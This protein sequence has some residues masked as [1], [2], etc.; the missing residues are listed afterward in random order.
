MNKKVHH[1]RIPNGLKNDPIK[2]KKIKQPHTPDE[3]FKIH[4]LIAFIGHRGSGKTHALVN[5]AKRYLDEGSFT[6]VFCISPTFESNP[7]FHILGIKKEDVYSNLH[8]SIAAIEDILAKCK[9]DSDDFDDYE[10]YMNAYRKWKRGKNLKLDEHTMLENNDFQKPPEIPRPS[11]LIVIDDMSHSDIYSTSRQNPFINLCLRHRHINHGKGCSIFMCV[12][13]FRSGIPLALRQNLQVMCIWPTHDSGQLEAIF[14]ES[15]KIIQNLK[16]IYKHNKNFNMPS[17]KDDESI[18]ALVWRRNLNSGNI[19]LQPM[20]QTSF[21]LGSVRGLNKYNFMDSTILGLRNGIPDNAEQN[22]KYRQKI[23]LNPYTTAMNPY[24]AK[25]IENILP[26]H[27]EVNP[28]GGTAGELN[29]L[30]SIGGS[31]LAFALDDVTELQ[32]RVYVESLRMDPRNPLSAAFAYK[33][34]LEQGAGDVQKGALLDSMRKGLLADT[35]NMATLDSK[36]KAGYLAK[37][38]LDNTEKKN[39]DQY[40]NDTSHATSQDIQNYKDLFHPNLLPS[41][42]LPGEIGT[43]I[44]AINKS[45]K[46]MAPPKSQTVDRSAK[47]DQD[48]LDKASKAAADEAAA[49]IAAAAAAEAVEEAASNQDTPVNVNGDPIGSSTDVLAYDNNHKYDFYNSTDVGKNAKSYEDLKQQVDVYIE[50]FRKQVDRG[51]FD[52]ENLL[53][54]SEYDEKNKEFS[55]LIR[56]LPHTQKTQELRWLLRRSVASILLNR[57]KTRVARLFW[58]LMYAH[59]PKMQEHGNRNSKATTLKPVTKPSQVPTTGATVPPTSSYSSK[60]GPPGPPGIAGPVVKSSKPPKT[61]KA[62]SKKY[63]VGGSGEE[64]IGYLDSTPSDPNYDPNNLKKVSKSSSQF[65][66]KAEK[67]V[68]DALHTGGELLKNFYGNKRNGTFDNTHDEGRKRF[69]R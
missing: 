47:E 15:L 61:I 29:N 9:T 27:H 34:F 4:S 18:Q 53:L 20:Q 40:V 65:L 46:S 26:R 11:P 13:N 62:P 35:E 10:A 56:E 55:R 52:V 44:D 6:R 67:V 64:D 23:Q 3:L 17:L 32:Q 36:F 42:G 21:A 25:D 51:D 68:S 12:Q 8:N 49:E 24:L 50:A 33:A 7:V 19:D 66:G 69:R 58:N 63:Y 48:A 2:Y 45:Y 54:K 38:Q 30:A 43:S 39:L 60:G 41:K 22:I 59:A 5:L 1:V 31:P 28:L 14:H 57:G 37:R 16:K